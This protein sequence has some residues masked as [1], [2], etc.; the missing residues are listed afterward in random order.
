MHTNI[1]KY[2]HAH[3]HTHICTHI[4]TYTHTQTHTYTHIHT[5]R[6]R[7]IYTHINE[8]NIIFQTSEGFFT[9]KSRA[10]FSAAIMTLKVRSRGDFL[11]S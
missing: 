3:M 2:A 9:A 11:D 1:Y 4:Y 8:S 10:P 7:H 5:H 6:H